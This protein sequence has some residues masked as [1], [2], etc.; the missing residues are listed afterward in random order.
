VKAKKRTIVEH[1]KIVSDGQKMNK[2]IKKTILKRLG[3]LDNSTLFINR[4][5]KN[6]MSAYGNTGQGSWAQNYPLDNQ[7]QNLNRKNLAGVAPKIFKNRNNKKTG[8]KA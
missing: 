8:R 2:N 1:V 6:Q 5:V 3:N 4:G 7:H